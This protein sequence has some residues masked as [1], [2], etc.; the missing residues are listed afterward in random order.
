MFSSGDLSNFA[1]IND[2]EVLMFSRILLSIRNKIFVRRL[3]FFLFL[4]KAVK[5]VLCG[6]CTCTMFLKGTLQRAAGLKIT[7]AT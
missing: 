1:A 6:F 4:W 7:F 5:A 3:F 2:V